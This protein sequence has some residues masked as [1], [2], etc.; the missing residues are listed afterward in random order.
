L[1]YVL[2][3]AYLVVFSWLVTKIRFFTTAGVS[4]SQVI[5]LF[6]LK[7][8]AGIFYGWMGLYYGTYAQ[9]L[10]TRVLHQ[11]GVM[12][13]HIL[14][15]NP[16]EYVTNLFDN[17]Y[18]TW[19]KLFAS[20][21]SFWNDLKGN[22]FVKLLS[23][24]DILSFGYYYV[25]VIFYSFITLFGPF[26]I[27]RV[28]RDLFPA[29]STLV[30]L[31]TF[32]IPSFIYWTSG[33]HREGLIFVALCFIIYHLYFGWKESHY[34]L[35]RWLGILSALLVLFILR[36]FLMLL[37]LPAIIAWLLSTRWPRRG[38]AI[39]TGVYLFSTLVFFTAKYIDPHLDFPQAVVN[40]QQDFLRLQGGA[41][42]IPI[43]EL[44]PTFSSF[45]KNTPQAI[46]LALFR[47]FPGDVSH[48]LSLAACIEVF[49]ILLLVLLL[50]LFRK[51][52]GA[53]ARNPVYLCLF[54]SFSILLAT[55]F[56]IN[57]LGAIV[58]YRSVVI[59][60]TM[61]PVVALIDWKRIEALLSGKTKTN[62]T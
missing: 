57:N 18:H 42:T 50:I 23:L 61:M 55:G 56:S 10:D 33:I 62:Q 11:A 3:I 25:N 44:E 5:I 8:L 39:F 30:L 24:F 2:F 58:R 48:L 45:V 38:L 28:M 19:G 13:Y 59:P 36:N 15:T 14:M 37:A 22:F 17:P 40:K 16:G 60:L 51:R 32:L 1:E 41:S 20:Q 4:K 43:K 7:V 26:A 27:F 29:R 9:M 21:D 6:L 52:N 31:A 46:T 54:L 35:K 53:I 12:E 47:P 34:S 49:F